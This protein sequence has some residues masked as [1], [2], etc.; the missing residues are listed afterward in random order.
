MF[1][2]K[3]VEYCEKNNISISAFEKKCGLTNGTVNGWKTKGSNPSFNS[4]EK[5]VKATKIPISKWIKD[6]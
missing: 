6:W 4:L 5:I 1:Y 2:L 3:V